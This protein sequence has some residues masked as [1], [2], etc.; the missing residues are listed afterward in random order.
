MPGHRFYSA[1]ETF[2]GNLVTLD[3]EE[4]HHALSVL[5][6]RIGDAASVFDGHGREFMAT[7]AELSKRRVLL[8][9]GDELDGE[10]ESPLNLTLAA[11]LLKAD[12]FEWV[13]QKAVELGVT[14]I[15]PLVTEHTEIGAVRAVSENRLVRWRRIALDATKQCGR[16]VLTTLSEPVGFDH[17]LT[18]S[19]SEVNVFFAERGAGPWRDGDRTPKSATAFIG[20]EGG[21]SG[22][23]TAM[24]DEVGCHL[25][26]LGPRVLRAETASV[27]AVGLLQSDWGD[28]R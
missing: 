6:L 13:I 21:W 3:D 22:Q 28:F 1:P 8:S 20:P 25:V 26:T 19:E 7:V 12:K 15:V 10:F 14:R 16:R 4:A 11:A 17:A 23:E 9:L 24:A 27:L 18:T 5:R 2:A